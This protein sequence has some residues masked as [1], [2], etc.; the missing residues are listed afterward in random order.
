MSGWAPAQTLWPGNVPFRFIGND[1]R[2][3]AKPEFISPLTDR[4]WARA[5][6]SS[7]IRPAFG[8]IS[9]RYCAIASVFQTFAPSCVRQGTR[10]EGASS[11]SSLRASASSIETITSSKSSPE[12]FA[13]NQPR[14]DH[15][16]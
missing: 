15:D 2:R 13:I 16:E 1:A 5:M 6:R 14:S 8:L 3:L 12:N 4:Q 9:F 7:G 10:I 11:R